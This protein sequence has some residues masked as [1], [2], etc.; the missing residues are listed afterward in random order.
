MKKLSIKQ[1]KLIR[2]LLIL[3]GIVVGALIW[4]VLPLIL[5]KNTSSSASISGTK[6]VMLP[7]IILP[8][9]AFLDARKRSDILSTNLDEQAT[10]T[11]ELELT[12]ARDQIL[13]ATIEDI[14]VIVIMVLAA[15]I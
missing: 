6:L 4:F 7:T 15:V 13:Y 5:G 1:L 9:F 14:I 11:K 3:G 12:I 10:Y 2:N 8:L